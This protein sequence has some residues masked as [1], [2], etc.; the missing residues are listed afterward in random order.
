[1]TLSI[2]Q[3]ALLALIER[4]YPLLWTHLHSQRPVEEWLL[5]LASMSAREWLVLFRLERR[6]QEQEGQ[7]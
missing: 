2:R 7:A 3:R 6:L 1:M 5:D 4:F